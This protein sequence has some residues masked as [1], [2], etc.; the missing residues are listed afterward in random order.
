MLAEPFIRFAFPEIAVIAQHL[1]VVGKN[2]MIQGRLACR[3]RS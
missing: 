3:L 1:A 2:M